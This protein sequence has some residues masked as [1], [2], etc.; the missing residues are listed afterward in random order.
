MKKQISLSDYKEVEMQLA[1]IAEKSAAL[2]SDLR[3]DVYGKIYRIN[4]TISDAGGYAYLKDEKRTCVV[5]SVKDF[6]GAVFVLILVY[7]KNT[8]HRNLRIRAWQNLETLK[9]TEVKR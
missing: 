3:R 9:L 5:T 8:G 7:N 2:M 1:G 6:Y 4:G